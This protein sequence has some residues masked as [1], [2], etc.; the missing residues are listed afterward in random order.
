MDKIVVSIIQPDK[1]KVKGEFFHVIVPGVEGDF[2]IAPEHTPMITKIRPGLLYL[3]HDNS[4]AEKYAIHDGFV[5]VE[6][7]QVNIVCDIIESEDEIDLARAKRA[8]ERAEKRMKSEQEDIDFRRA[9]NALKR[10]LT[11]ISVRTAE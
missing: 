2:G 6:N 10:A 4:K 7:N 5:T 3:F 8:K 1:T 9:E 11:R